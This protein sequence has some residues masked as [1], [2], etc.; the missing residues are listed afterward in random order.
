MRMNPS[1]L[2]VCGPTLGVA[3]VLPGAAGE[4]WV[5]AVTLVGAADIACH[6]RAIPACRR[7]QPKR[8]RMPDAVRP[9]RRGGDPR[10][11]DSA[12]HRYVQAPGAETEALG[13]ARAFAAATG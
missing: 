3:A 10:E 7:W 5:M 2:M 12:S 6:L 11:A 8:Y 13:L 4:G 9:C 1:L